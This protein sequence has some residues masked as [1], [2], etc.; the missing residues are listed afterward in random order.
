MLKEVKIEVIDLCDRYCKHCSSN[1]TYTR[2]HYQELDHKLVCRIIDEAKE[3]GAESIVFTGG[4]ATLWQPLPKAIEYAKTKGFKI[5]LYTMCY[6]TDKNLNLLEQL[7]KCGLDEIVYSTTFELVQRDDHSTYSLEEFI[8]ALLYKVDVKFSFHH[9]VTKETFDEI[10]MRNICELL[11]SINQMQK[12]ELKGK[13]SFLRLVHHGRATSDLELTKEDLKKLRALV[14]ELRAKYGKDFIKIGSPFNILG[15]TNSSCIAGD[16]TMIV[17]FNGHAYPC[18]AMKYFEYAGFGG[19][20][21]DKSLREIYESTYFRSIRNA[22]AYAG[23]ECLKCSNYCIC[24]GGCLGQK[25]ITY[26]TDEDSLTFEQ[27]ELNNKRTINKF[28]IEEIETNNAI[29]YCAKQSD[30]NCMF[31]K[32][33]L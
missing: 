18:D 21:Y 25:M 20:I 29:E 33:I 22:R 2:N 26:L 3:M 32:K 24:K 14:I 28:Q 4:E 10:K 6:R 11:D 7:V 31:H 5:K 13:L 12:L 16:E 19:S 8:M 27:H 9:A 17:G 1:A 30:P 15:I 23:I